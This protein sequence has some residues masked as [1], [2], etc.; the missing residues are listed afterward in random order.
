MDKRES[1]PI[2]FTRKKKVAQEDGYNVFFL[3][4]FKEKNR[5]QNNIKKKTCIRVYRTT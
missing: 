2:S 5:N 3:F 1:T 4:F